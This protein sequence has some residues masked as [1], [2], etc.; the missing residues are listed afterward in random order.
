MIKTQD[1]YIVAYGNIIFETGLGRYNYLTSKVPVQIPVIGAA[2]A[3]YQSISLDL[4]NRI[5]YCLI[6]GSLYLIN[7]DTWQVITS[8]TFNST[9]WIFVDKARGWLISVDAVSNLNLKKFSLSDLSLLSSFQ[10]TTLTPDNFSCDYDFEGGIMYVHRTARPTVTASLYKINVVNLTLVNNTDTAAGGIA[11]NPFYTPGLSF[12]SIRNLLITTT[13]AVTASQ[14][15]IFDANL[16]PV[17][18]NVVSNINIGVS[19]AKGIFYDKFTSTY[20]FQII[21]P[22]D[23]ASVASINSSTLLP[24]SNPMVS[25]SNPGTAN[26]CNYVL[27]YTDTDGSRYCL[28]CITQGINIFKYQ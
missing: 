23:A 25:F 20:N 28:Q 8:V 3:V 26:F 10:I 13:G 6:N 9:S 2:N 11:N 15:Q 5:I 1:G 16:I 14:I 21:V 17:N 4:D 22:H 27:F 7:L 19:T 18:N 12:D 24:T